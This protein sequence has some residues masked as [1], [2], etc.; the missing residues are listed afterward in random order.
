MKAT[1]TARPLRFWIWGFTFIFLLHAFA[2][3]F[4]GER[5]KHDPPWQRPPPFLHAGG[6]PRVDAGL[7]NLTA[8]GD[9]T[10]F[11]LPHAEGFAGGAW[12]QLRPDAPKL[13]NWSAPPEWLALD[14]ES[15]GETL[16]EYAATNR[17]SEELLLATLRAPKAVEIRLPSEPIVTNTTASIDGP[18]AARTLVRAPSLPNASHND[19]LRRSVVAVSVNGEGLVE[20]ASL[21]RESGAPAAD[22]RAVELAH[23]FVFQPAPIPDARAREAAPP[24]IGRIVFTWQVLPPTNGLSAAS[25]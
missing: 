10:L 5:E 20:S 25:P 1:R 2:I 16:R 3:F 17:P 23:S 18:L 15:L 19:V 11:A 8:L 22:E 14:A 9:P 13:T 4:Y 7:A 6:D 24:T 21:M 12:L